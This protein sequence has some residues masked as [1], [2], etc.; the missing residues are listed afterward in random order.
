MKNYMNLFLVAVT[1]I[2]LAVSCDSNN[3]STTDNNVD[4][5]SA[6]TTRAA[7]VQEKGMEINFQ[8]QKITLNTADIIMA[9]QK[10]G[11]AEADAEVVTDLN[12][13]FMGAEKTAQILDVTFTASEE[14]V[15]NGMFIFGIQS[16]NAKDLVM[17]VFDEE[18]F[19]QVANNSFSINGENANNYKALNV[20][21]LDNG[22]Y[23]FRLRDNEGKELNRQV[24][25]AN[26][27]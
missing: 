23:N 11:A 10:A 17:E 24:K 26:P 7:G 4:A 20:Q 12:S 22:V 25:V 27:E 13:A 5:A 2:L 1:S 14:A 15:E 8:G 3:V 6:Q 21:A 18:G 9:S 19:S 16:E